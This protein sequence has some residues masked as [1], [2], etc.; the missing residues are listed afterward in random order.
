[1]H[2]SQYALSSEHRAL[3][4]FCLSQSGHYS[5]IT[6]ALLTSC[7]GKTV[8]AWQATAAEHV[9]EVEST[10]M[11]TLIAQRTDTDATEHNDA[12]LMVHE[13]DQHILVSAP[14]G[15]MVLWISG[16]PGTPLQHVWT[17]TQRLRS[18]VNAIL[19]AVPRAS[20]SP[21]LPPLRARVV[22]RVRDYHM[23]EDTKETQATSY[24]PERQDYQGISTP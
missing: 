12:S 14:V 13:V 11:R 20:A 2:K 16:G 6:F 1:M 3:L 4:R 23:E 9:P 18:H 22:G 19:H 15:P 7:E 24:G 8:A 17:L 5:G 10:A 21:A